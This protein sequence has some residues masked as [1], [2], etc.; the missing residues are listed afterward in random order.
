[1][2]FAARIRNLANPDEL[3]FLIVAKYCRKSE[4]IIFPDV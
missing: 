3:S 1:M 4:K 2:S